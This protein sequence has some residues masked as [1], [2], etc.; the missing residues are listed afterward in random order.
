MK[1]YLLIVSCVLIY[2]LGYSQDD[3]KPDMLRQTLTEANNSTYADVA[4]VPKGVFKTVRVQAGAT[5]SQAKW[6]FFDAA[7]NDFIPKWSRDTA[8]L[9]TVNQFNDDYA[10]YKTDFSGADGRVN[11][12]A[13][14]Y[15]TFNI[16]DIEANA[17]LAILETDFLPQSIDSVYQ[18]P[19]ESLVYTHQSVT[20]TIITGGALNAGEALWLRYTKDNWATSTFVLATLASGND[21]YEAVIPAQNSI[22]NIEYYVLTT[23]SGNT[24]PQHN[25]IDFLT[26]EMRPE[27]VG[28]NYTYTTQYPASSAGAPVIDGVFD[29]TGVWGSA[30]ATADGLEGWSAANAKKLYVT[31]DDYYYYFG[32]EVSA[33]DWN[34][35]GFV[36][37]TTTGGGSNEPWSRSITYAHSDL[38]DYVIKG[39]F[40][41]PFDNGSNSPFAQL[42]R[43]NG[44]AWEYVEH[45]SF[46]GEDETTFV[47]AKVL[48]SEIG[49]PG[50]VDI[51]FYITGNNIEHGTFDACPDDAVAV[52][53]NSQGAFTVLDNY[54]SSVVL[55]VELALFYGKAIEGAIHLSWIT[56][57]EVNNAGFEIE[58]SLNGKD[59]ETIGFV[60]GNGNTVEEIAYNFIDNN[61]SNGTSYY[62]LK[63][64]DFDGTYDYSVIIAVDFIKQVSFKLFPN[65]VR[66]NLIIQGLLNDEVNVAIIGMKG[67]ILYEGTARIEDNLSVDVSSLNQGLYYVQIRNKGGVIYKELFVKE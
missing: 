13:G 42:I 50:S 25:T 19:N 3:N 26:L 28:N 10:L 6:V 47:E 64:I 4:L 7:P 52:G 61:P 18:T 63:Q 16:Q 9:I 15:Y 67:Q 5:Q 27:I 14:K 24:S 11:I 56:L 60:E 30:V 31:Y 53:W 62:R 12:T 40:G 43:W 8:D 49:S 51:Q 38:P 37:N 48:K 22:E 36:I 21:T 55:P 59:F 46:I 45:T 39:H 29:G 17:D 58:K 66:D 20:V 41:D 32:A 54:Q 65:P 57:S 34:D 2:A 35:W 23:L 33:S 1:K 44:S